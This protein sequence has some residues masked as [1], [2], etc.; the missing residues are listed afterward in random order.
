MAKQYSFLV[1]KYP[2]AETGQDAL[3]AVRE[4]AKEG[5][6][7]LRDAVA[8]TKTDKGKIKIHQTK[9]DSIG[10][11]FVK[12]GVIGILFAALFGPVGWIAMGAA[13]GGLFA[14]FDRGI[15][16]RLL[17]ELG[18]DM[19]PDESAL[20]LLVEEADW[21]E[22]VARMKAHGFGGTVV[23]QELVGDDIEQVEKLLEDPKTVEAAPEELD[24]SAEPLPVAVEEALR[25]TRPCALLRSKGSKRPTQRSSPRPASR[26]RKTCSTSG[27][28][29]H[30]EESSP[31]RPA[32]T[33]SRS[34]NG[35]TK[36]T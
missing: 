24:V 23:V 9:D 30:D 3:A 15:K 17:K 22:A 32:S 20:A 19:T 7:K 21:A 18:Q 13:A 34:S 1:I 2:Y 8:I 26:P 29:P 35:Y 14:S 28:I 25:A 36:P 31:R 16:N 10:R 11:G 6:V 12:G 4:I 5:V 33:T 27:G